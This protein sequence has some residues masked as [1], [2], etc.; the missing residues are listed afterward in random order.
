MVAWLPHAR[1]DR[2]ALATADADG[3]HEKDAVRCWAVRSTMH[4][5]MGTILAGS[6]YPTRSCPDSRLGQIIGHPPTTPDV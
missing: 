4:T 1:L 2:A 3:T 6:R 5:A